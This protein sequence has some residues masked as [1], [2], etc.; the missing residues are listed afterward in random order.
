MKIVVL[1]IGGVG[2]VVGGALARVN[3]ETYFCARGENLQA[4]RQSGLTVRSALFGNFTVRPKAAS[5]NAAD[6][7]TADVVFVA[8]KGCGIEAAC[9]TIAPTVGPE[10]I[11]APLLNGVMVSEVMEP[12]LPRCVTTDAAIRVFSHIES[13]GRVVHTSGPCS[14]V[15]GMKDG[16]RL[17]KLEAAAE[18]LNCAGVKTRISGDILSESWAKYVTMCSNSVLFCYYDG[19]AGTVREDPDHE[20]VLRAIVG[21]M[22]AIAAAKGA[23]LPTD[24]VD[25]HIEAFSKMPPDTMTSLYRDLSGGRPAAETEL[26]HLVGRFVEFSDQ[27]GIP[28]PY[29]RAVY[30]KYGG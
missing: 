17:A 6:F 1:G 29:H 21:S 5:E 16:G 13:P 19:P 26:R 2:G 15:M 14:V 9:R 10:T 3:A 8:C 11:V 28:A 23:T 4:I 24:T 7:G 18:L 12:L 20:K 30:D 27:T 22:A 25:R